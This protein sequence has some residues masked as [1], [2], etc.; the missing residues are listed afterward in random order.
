MRLNVWKE[1]QYNF[2]QIIEHIVI[3]NSMQTIRLFLQEQSE[4][5][6]VGL[7]LPCSQA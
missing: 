1:P 3:A 5:L 2:F 4:A 7:V 6:Q